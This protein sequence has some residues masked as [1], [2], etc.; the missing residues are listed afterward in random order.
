MI[1]HVKNYNYAI[2]VD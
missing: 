2:I 1:K